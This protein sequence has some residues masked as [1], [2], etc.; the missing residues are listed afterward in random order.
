MN[1]EF[2]NKIKNRILRKHLRHITV[3][4]C[5]T[6]REEEREI[7]RGLLRKRKDYQGKKIKE[8]EIEFAKYVGSK[9]AI[10]FGKG[11]VGLFAILKVLKIKKDD[12]IIISTGNCIVVPNAV[13]FARGKPVYV[14]MKR[15]TYEPSLVD[16]KR[17][18]SNK[19]KAIILTH[20]FGQPV[21]MDPIISIAKNNNICIIEDS[22]QSL[23]ATYK[24]KKVGAIG[25]FGFFSFD[26]S[27]NITTGQGGMVTTNNEK[28]YKELLKI[29]ETFNE[30]SKEYLKSIFSDLLNSRLLEPSIYFIGE[31]I[32]VIQC[33]LNSRFNLGIHHVSINSNELNSNIPNNFKIKM[34]DKQAILGLKQLKKVN[35]LN[36]KRTEITERYNKE[37]G[38]IG[39]KIP[40]KIKDTNP[41]CLRYTLE[42]KDRERVIEVF[43]RNQVELGLWFDFPIYPKGKNLK[44]LGY[45]IGSCPISEAKSEKIVN[46]PNHPKMSKKDIERVIELVKENSHLFEKIE[47]E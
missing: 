18:I 40:K 16:I 3:N 25:D 32:Y 24:N 38:K 11:R 30:P 31:P 26:Y 37:F 20:L 35:E 27:K 19:T 36:D 22:A 15:D 14:D 44:R 29:R 47:N 46:L 13:I 39:I 45:R 10:S 8:F 41:V 7:V 4:P 23:G 2:L 6:I 33:W 9:Y 1:F 21:D 5:P 34:S 12:E 28:F 43:S 42:A 17:K